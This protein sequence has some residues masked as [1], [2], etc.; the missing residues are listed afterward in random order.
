MEALSL[1]VLER[2]VQP[3]THEE[4]WNPDAKSCAS[5]GCW[6]TREI[7]TV[8]GQGRKL[9]LNQGDNCEES[10]PLAEDKLT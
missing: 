2:T 7:A 5:P 10:F 3:Q 8:L 1:V 4:T 9:R 6:G